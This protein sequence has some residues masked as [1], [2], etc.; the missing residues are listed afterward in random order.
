MG[1]RT[2]SGHGAVRLKAGR[3]SP[4]RLRVEL[5]PALLPVPGNLARGG[6]TGGR[7]QPA[8]APAAVVSPMG[9]GVVAVVE[10]A[11]CTLVPQVVAGARAVASGSGR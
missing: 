2:I 1:V 6:M 9:V 11:G 8:V 7:R 3:P 10:V 5:M 4:I